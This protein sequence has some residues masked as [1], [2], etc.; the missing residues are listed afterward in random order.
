MLRNIVQ[1]I[2]TYGLWG[3]GKKNEQVCDEVV[4]LLQNMFKDV[5]FGDA[6][7]QDLKKYWYRSGIASTPFHTDIGVIHTPKSLYHAISKPSEFLMACAR[8]CLQ[9]LEEEQ[10]EATQNAVDRFKFTIM[11]G[12]D[13]VAPGTAKKNDRLVCL[14]GGK[15]VD[16]KTIHAF[17]NA[18]RAYHTFRG[19]CPDDS[20]QRQIAIDR[21]EVV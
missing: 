17:L 9:L 3:G 16:Y 15:V 21:T 1:L 6:Y 2:N 4:D 7:I 11:R 12:R 19:K 13:F 8:K 20:W 5:T 14:L 18:A 10:L